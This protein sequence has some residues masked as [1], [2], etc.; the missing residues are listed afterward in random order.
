M[1]EWMPDGRKRRKV[2]NRLVHTGNPNLPGWN[3]KP[4]IGI[5][6][7]K[8]YWFKSAQAAAESLGL[9]RTNISKCCR[10]ERKR[11]GGFNWKF[12]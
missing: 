2:R 4:I 6:E 7:G 10:G 12:A 1:S 8:E 5:K 3:K 9:I 11:C